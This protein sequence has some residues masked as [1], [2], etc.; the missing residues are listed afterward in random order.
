MQNMSAFE[1]LLIT[2]MSVMAAAAIVALV[3]QNTISKRFMREI[4]V[5]LALVYLSFSVAAFVAFLKH[6]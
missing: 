5:V 3:F 2:A 6:A 4:Q 1:I